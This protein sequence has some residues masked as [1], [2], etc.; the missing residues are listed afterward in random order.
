MKER[1]IKEIVQLQ[2][3]FFRSGSTRDIEYRKQMLTRLEEGIRANE[4]KLYD[5][6]Q[7][8][9]GKSKAESY[10]A[11]IA[12]VLGELAYIRK[13]LRK[14]SKPKK[15][16]ATSGTFP[17]KS[18]IYMEPYGV[19]L[20]LAPWNYPVFLAFSPV[21]GAIAAG[22]TVVLKC[23]KSS[24]NCARVIRKIISESL[25]AEL[26]YPAEAEIDY[27]EVLDQD[28]QYIFFTG[29]PR[30]GKQIMETASKRLIPVSLELG[31]KSPCIVTDSANIKLAAKRIIW[32]KLLNAGQT[33]ISIDYILVDRKVKD[34]LV[35]ELKAEIDKTYGAPLLNKDYP[36]IVS[37]HHFNRLINLIAEERKLGK[38]IGGEGLASKRKIEPA[39]VTEADFTHPSMEEEIFGPILPVIAYDNLDEAVE[40]VNDRPHPLAT[41]IFTED[42]SLAKSLIKRL[43]FGGGCINDTILHIANHHMPFGG[44]GN[45][46]MGNYHGYYS[47]RTFTHEKS[48]FWGSTKID[49]PIRYG[50]LDDK[51]WQFLKK[52]I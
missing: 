26:C 12:Q 36:K 24:P 39:I 29:S 52:F 48:V 30:V 45:S 15:A 51:K 40:E 10:M 19:V 31:G 1:S 9:L 41:Y 7:E 8:D 20:V 49:V 32:G 46:G 43:P 14:W 28:Y 16:P 17:G 50:P 42:A 21:I 44:V 3:K 18:R 38:V 4:N 11:E 47:F 37:D 6:F 25:P 23:S 2:T 27:D 5:A 13:H 34:A 33:C 22:N 35:L